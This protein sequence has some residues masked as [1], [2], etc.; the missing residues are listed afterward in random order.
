MEIVLNDIE[1]RIL[2]C[3]IE[4]EMTTPDYYPMTLNSLTNA[5]NQKSNRDPVVSY[6]ETTVEQGLNSLHGKGLAELVHAVGSRVHK[7]RHSL[8][9]RFDL[10]RQET[11][12]LCEL[13]LRGPQT[14][15]EIRARAG[16]MAEFGSIEKAE[17]II[18]GLTEHGEPLVVR[19]PREPGKKESRYM[20]LLSGQPEISVSKS[21]VET[22]HMQAE[23]E[24]LRRL[25]EE[26]ASVR[27]D[28]GALKQAFAEFKAQF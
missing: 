27:D 16:R 1:V 14:T 26:L 25:E 18:T 24:R 2:G 10:D 9:Y 23:D 3:L 6:D 12:V 21:S 5:C 11:A 8:L 22:Q 13:M 17:E 19:L 15:G 28:L 7:F 20:H 4:K